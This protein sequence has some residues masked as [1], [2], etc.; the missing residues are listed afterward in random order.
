VAEYDFKTVKTGF[1]GGQQTIGVDP[2]NEHS[3]GKT[4]FLSSSFANGKNS[5]KK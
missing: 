1:Y 4:F 5:N 2:L 3:L